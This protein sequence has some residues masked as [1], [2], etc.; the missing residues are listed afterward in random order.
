MI[1]HRPC[2]I[3]AKEKLLKN[4]Q[5][6]VANITKM[7]SSCENWIRDVDFVRTT[8]HKICHAKFVTA[9]ALTALVYKNPNRLSFEC[10]VT[11]Q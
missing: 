2:W 9:D 11:I 4:A 1:A 8:E 6:D 5:L 3:A 7:V 10:D